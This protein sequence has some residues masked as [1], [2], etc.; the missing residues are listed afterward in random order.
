MLAVLTQLKDAARIET[1]LADVSAAGDY[2]KTDNEALLEAAAQ[3]APQR[4]D[5]PDE[6]GLELVATGGGVAGG[7]GGIIVS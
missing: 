2:G 6:G 1:F 7:H 4:A 5:R 3:L